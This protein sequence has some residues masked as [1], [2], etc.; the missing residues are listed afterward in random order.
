MT[1]QKQQ[2]E[3]AQI[4]CM[5]WNNKKKTGYLGKLSIQKSFC[6]IICI[7]LSICTHISKQTACCFHLFIYF[8]KLLEDLPWRIDFNV[9]DTRA[10]IC[11][12]HLRL[13][14]TATLLHTRIYK[15]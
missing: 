15:M 6:E 8:Y 10:V 4:L 3:N 12:T 9:R 1:G 5:K 2:I 13:N 11:W 7:Y 14:T